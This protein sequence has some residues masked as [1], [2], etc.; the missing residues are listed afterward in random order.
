MIPSEFEWLQAQRAM[1]HLMFSGLPVNLRLRA[2]SPLAFS[3]AVDPFF[4]ANCRV[5][6]TVSG[7]SRLFR[8]IRQQITWHPDYGIELHAGGKVPIKLSALISG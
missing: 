8:T 1:E 7:P 4:E 2:G 5:H 3:E 6:D